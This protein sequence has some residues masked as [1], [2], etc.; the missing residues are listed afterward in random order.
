MSKPGTTRELSLQSSHDED[1]K[2]RILISTIGSRGEVQ[3]ILG[4]ALELQ[5]LGHRAVLCVPPNF[6]GW[7]ESYGIECVPIGPDVQKLSVPRG[8]IKRRK[9]SWSTMRQLV[10]ASVIEQFRVMGNAADGCDLIVVA[11]DLLHAGRSLAESRKLPYIHAIYCPATLKSHKHPPPTLGSVN[12]SQTLPS[13]VNRLLWKASG[14]HWNALYRAVLNE[15]REALGLAPVKDAPSH[16]A[17]EQPWLAVDPVLGRVPPTKSMRAIQTGAW[18]LA[19]KRPLPDPLEQ[20]LLEG[21]PPIYFGFGS[22]RARTHTGRTV[23]EAARALGRRAIVSHGW[24]GLDVTDTGTDCIAIGDV[25]HEK[26]FPRVAVIVHHGG[27]GTTT[28]AARSGKPQVVVPHIYDQYFWAHRVQQLGIGVSAGRAAQLT[29]EKLVRALR[30][31]LEPD[32]AACAQVLA[33]R[34]DLHGTR[35]AAER[36]VKEFK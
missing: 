31:C 28:A 24:A 35:V 36:L 6:Q 13:L 5:A 3:P 17:T 32:I 12:R 11:G 14:W 27:A 33:S 19:D 9:P 26:L 25:S 2:K 16:I 15:Q 10:R 34:I 4:L 20:F 30:R 29:V 1:K 7:V 22:M 8:D 21:K 23:I 18:F